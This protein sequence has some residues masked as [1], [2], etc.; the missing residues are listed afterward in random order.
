M[1]LLPCIGLIYFVRLKALKSKFFAIPDVVLR[2]TSE[3][4]NICP[5]NR[6]C[7]DATLSET[8][9]PRASDVDPQQKGL[10]SRNRDGELEIV[11]NN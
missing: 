8:L 6:T 1:G 2:S 11:L 10:E 7:T 5:T 9:A 3:A 4:E